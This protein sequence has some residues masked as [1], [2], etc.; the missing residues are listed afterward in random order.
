MAITLFEMTST[1][2]L[3]DFKHVRW[4]L[5]SKKKFQEK[6]VLNIVWLLLKVVSNIE[7]NKILG[8]VF[9]VYAI[10]FRLKQYNSSWVCS[11][12]VYKLFSIKKKRLV[13]LRP[14]L[15]K[16]V[17]V[18]KTQWDTFFLDSIITKVDNKHKNKR[19]NWGQLNR[20]KI[21]STEENCI[22]PYRQE[23][24]FSKSLSHF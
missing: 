11:V 22:A 19:K 4:F 2:R 18:G 17:F 15:S 6:I 9:S 16:R 20:Y 13:L 1:E 8:L 23:K 10:T 14:R 7:K 3:L 21:F 12:C 5:K 24:Y